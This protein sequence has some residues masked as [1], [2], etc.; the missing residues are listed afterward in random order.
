MLTALFFAGRLGDRF[1][2]LLKLG[3]PDEVR[4]VLWKAA[5][6]MIASAPWQGLGLGTF[7]DAYPLYSNQPLPFVMDRAHSDYLELIAGLGIPGAAAVFVA[8]MLLVASCLRGAFVRRRDAFFSRAA[9][10]AAVVVALHSSVD[11]E[12]QVPAV[13][14]SYATLLAIGL[15]QSERSVDRTKSAVNNS[16]KECIVSVERSC[17]G[18]H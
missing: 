7:P 3:T 11:F 2:D 1:G 17:Q 6:R 18:L 14:L 13:A 15:A 5:G 4:L 12:L 10:C 8:L 9:V 16:I